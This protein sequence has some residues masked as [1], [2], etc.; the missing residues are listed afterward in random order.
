MS[1]ICLGMSLGLPHTR[2]WPVGGVFIA[3]N[4]N[5]A[6]G[7]KLLL[8]VVH[9]T[10]RWGHRTVRCPCPVRLAV[11]LSEQVTIGAQ[12]FSHRTVRPH[13]GQ[14]GGLPSGCHLELAVRA[15]VPGAPDSPACGIG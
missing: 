13:T 4:T 15:A 14:S 5:I 11:S 10:V 12:T 7:G 9:Q 8:S 6:V 3:P 2:K 1:T